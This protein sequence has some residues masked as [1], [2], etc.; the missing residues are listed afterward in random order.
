MR[1]SVLFLVACGGGKGADKDT[2]FRDGVTF[3]DVRPI[4]E[5]NCSPCHFGSTSPAAE[6]LV[7]HPSQ[8]VEVP[9]AATGLDLV[10]PGSTEDSYLWHKLVDTQD[11]VG[12]SGG[13]MPPA[14]SLGDDDLET[15]RSWI[16]GG[17]LGDGGPIPEAD[18][19]GD[20]HPGCDSGCES[21]PGSVAHAPWHNRLTESPDISWDAVPGAVAYEVSIGTTAGDDDIECWTEVSGTSHTFRA[22]WVLE[23][24]QTY[25]ANV[26]AVLPNDARSDVT[27]SAGWT[28]D[29]APPTVPTDLNDDRMPV[30]G[31]ASWNHPTDDD[32]AGFSH[33][34][35]AIGTSPGSDDSV[36][37]TDVGGSVSASLSTEVATLPQGAWYW[38]SVR[39][40][41]VADNKSQPT[42]STGFITCPDA[43]SFVASKGEEDEVAP[44]PTTKKA[45]AK[46]KK[47]S[48]KAT[49]AKATKAKATKANAATPKTKKEAKSPARA[50]TTTRK[51]T[52]STSNA[53][54]AEAGATSKAEEEDKKEPEQP[55]TRATRSSK[56]KKK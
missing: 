23:A 4:F 1:W 48:T 54:T 22:I 39:A 37:W 3:D 5:A 11:D 53:D 30:D 6:L 40:V 9:H 25:V 19:C 35:V 12:G 8:F 10:R 26:R 52:R 36:A 20:L 28:V 44:T 13:A 56:R 47:A 2:N 46:S 50:T 38:L 14:G 45:A 24:E 7:E 33:F 49:K 51:R 34:E 21:G 32:G 18:L 42:V 29:I 55:K 16:L 15:V 41:D 27:T 17:A 31:E 43:F